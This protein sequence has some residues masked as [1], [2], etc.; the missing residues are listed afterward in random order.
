MGLI[1]AWYLILEYYFVVDC[2]ISHSIQTLLIVDIDLVLFFAH[3]V[4]DKHV[5]PVSNTKS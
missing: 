1:H 3:P 5:L 4:S 2:R